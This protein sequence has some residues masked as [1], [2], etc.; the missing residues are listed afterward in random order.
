M[1]DKFYSLPIS[2]LVELLFLLT[3]KGAANRI[4]EDLANDDLLDRFSYGLRRFEAQHFASGIGKI[5]ARNAIAI[6]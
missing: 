6:S 2:K 5:L 3:P 1:A 4:A